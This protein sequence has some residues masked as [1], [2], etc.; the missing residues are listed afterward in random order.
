MEIHEIH[1]V[2]CPMTPDAPDI[3]ESAKF[4][5]SSLSVFR[6]CDLDGAGAQI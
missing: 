5:R 3:M 4:R 6:V 1:Q 2:K